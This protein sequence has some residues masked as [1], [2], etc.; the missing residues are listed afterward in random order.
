MTDV[1]AASP[2]PRRAG[3][4]TGSHPPRFPGRFAASRGFRR[5][6]WAGIALV[7][8]V[9][10]AVGAA[11]DAGP[12]SSADR[13]QR[14]ASTLKCPECV[15][16]S[17]GDSNSSRARAIRVEIARGVESG[18]TDDEIVQGI[19]DRYGETVTLVPPGTGFAGLVWA[20]PVLALI[21]ALAALGATF[22]RWRRSPVLHASDDDRA[23]VE[24]A[25][26]QR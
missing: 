21:L 2:P 10:L 20:L 26:A 1:P 11:G 4:G 19:V 6:A 16:Q 14:I 12:E 24:Q 3:P 23:L 7:V 5:V 25:R 8:V 15:G 17:V 18:A 9:S 22:L 13:V